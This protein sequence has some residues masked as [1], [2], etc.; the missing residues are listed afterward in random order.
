MGAR[1]LTQ[2]GV[3]MVLIRKVVITV[4]STQLLV[5]F[6]LCRTDLRPAQQLLFC[7]VLGGYDT[8][9]EFHPSCW[10]A[11]GTRSCFVGPDL[12]NRIDFS[13]Q[14]RGLNGSWLRAPRQSAQRCIQQSTAKPTGHTCLKV[15]VDLYL[16]CID[17]SN[18]FWT[19]L[20]FI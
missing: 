8:S 5:L 7:Q 2:P 1:R 3:G 17:L 19:R 6:L 18:C 12:H 9:I 13:P 14:G 11:L 15:M 16:L 20:M 10:A 4:Q